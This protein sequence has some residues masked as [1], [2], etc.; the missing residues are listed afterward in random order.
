MQETFNKRKDQTRIN[1]KVLLDSLRARA[2]EG[3]KNV[4]NGIGTA[5]KHRDDTGSNDTL[6]PASEL[7][8]EPTL[9]QTPHHTMEFNVSPALE[10]DT[11]NP[12]LNPALKGAL[13]S[14]HNTTLK[15]KPDLALQGAISPDMGCDIGP[16]TFSPP[17]DKTID[18]DLE[19]TLIHPLQ[20]Q[21]KIPHC[22]QRIGSSTAACGQYDNEVVP[23]VRDQMAKN[24]IEIEIHRKMG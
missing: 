21:L 8:L 17:L 10:L 12:S 15:S 3:I 22:D 14:T 2:A 20:E 6:N 4:T 16:D 19:C 18:P 7:T 23:L 5:V 9:E 11:I 13:D 1:L 24:S